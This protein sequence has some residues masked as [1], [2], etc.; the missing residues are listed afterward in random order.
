VFLGRQFRWRR[1]LILDVLSDKGKV[2]F[3]RISVKPGKPTAF[4]LV[5]GKPF[6]GMPGY[7]SSCLSNAHILLVRHCA[8][9]RGW[10]RMRSKT[11]TAPLGQRVVSSP[12][13]HQFLHGARCRRRGDAGVQGLGRHHSMSQADGY[14]ESSR[15]VPTSS[16]KA[17][18]VEVTLF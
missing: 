17:R 12:G 8:G 9:S 16:K 4:G 18:L 7:P 13:R 10:R 1:D 11:V 15:P 2:L 14:I 6:F 3:S 5:G